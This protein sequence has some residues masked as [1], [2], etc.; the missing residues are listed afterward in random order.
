MRPAQ[1]LAEML[2][3]ET[4]LG[5]LY[6]PKI[7]P[8]G[9]YVSGADA[10]A[11]IR[12]AAQGQNGNRRR[13]P[14]AYIDDLISTGYSFVIRDGAQLL[15]YDGGNDLTD[16]G[17]NMA[18]LLQIQPDTPV[19]IIKQANQPGT[20]STAAEVFGMKLTPEQ[21]AARAQLK[22]QQLSPY[23]PT[24][25]EERAYQSYVQ[26]QNQAPGL[27]TAPLA[28][29]RQ[30]RVPAPARPKAAPVAPPKQPQQ[31]WWKRFLP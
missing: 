19:Q 3:D 12:K 25:E 13:S 10:K 26:K 14:D 31:P 16:M 9:W 21:K 27:A 22:K 29:P 24:P 30:K 15:V 7:P 20:P 5:I 4:A 6:G 11:V 18:Q 17:K 8:T 23:T 2:L 28:K 1:I